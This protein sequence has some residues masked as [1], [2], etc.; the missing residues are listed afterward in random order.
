MKKTIK[1][2]F[3]EINKKKFI[4][5]LLFV[6]AFVFAFVVFGAF[7]VLLHNPA[8]FPIDIKECLWPFFVVFIFSAFFSLFLLCVLPRLLSEFLICIFGGILLA[9]YTQL[10]FLNGKMPS[11][12]G[13]SIN[14]SIYPGLE[15]NNLMIW[16]TI[17]IIPL[18]VW[19]IEEFFKNK[20]WHNM[21]IFMS[22]LIFGMQLSGIVSA[23]ITS[24]SYDKSSE[25][26]YFSID[27]Q[28][29]LSSED[30]IVVFL[31]D[32]LDTYYMD[33]VLETW[34]ETSEYLTGFTYYKNNTSVYTYTFPSIT[35]LFTNEPYKTGDTREDYFDRAWQNADL[36]DELHNKGY[37]VNALLDG[38]STFYNKDELLGKFDNIK[39]ADIS[40][41]TV[42][43]SKVMDG[44][45]G[46]TLSRYMPYYL[47]DAFSSKNPFGLGDSYVSIKGIED[48]FTSNISDKSD[49]NYMNIL[50][51]KKININSKNKTFS[52][53]HFVSGH[54][55]YGYDENLNAIDV[56]NKNIHE[57]INSQKNAEY[58][59]EQYATKKAPQISG[60]FRII[61]EYL[62]QMKE[63]GIYENSTIIIMTDH[64]D[65]PA[66]DGIGDEFNGL[67]NRPMAS[68]LIKPKGNAAEPLNYD[69]TSE[70]SN[71][72]FAASILEIIGS[73]NE[74]FG[75]SYFDIIKNN[76][77]QTRYVNLIEW[78]NVSYSKYKGRYE[79]IGDA[80]ISDNWHLIDVQK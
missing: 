51:N 1:Q 19:I 35:A 33:K 5:M 28:F 29:T 60:T 11:L 70:L 55:P 56:D 15:Q 67:I 80:N 14:Y 40:Y 53:V 9:S 45:L 34:P 23:A 44:M 17:F 22:V 76:L 36:F 41:R 6:I 77:S 25:L 16:L 59:E 66:W 12:T 72:N 71:Q 38:T 26:H 75:L 43:W 63:L 2:L 50:Q 27:S 78:H 69:T 18:I 58:W 46:L 4:T 30:N 61:N 37:T 79:I 74:S 57:V 47:K 24:P 48:Y 54:P 7:D 3:P 20:I 8:D 42:R 39:Q 52:F 49:L 64:G 13:D 62:N 65:P 73:E 32:S 10:L 21:I 31:I 68:L